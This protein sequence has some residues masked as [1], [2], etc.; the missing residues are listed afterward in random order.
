[1]T[2]LDEFAE[3]F[4]LITPKG[5][6]YGVVNG[7]ILE[8]KDSPWLASVFMSENLTLNDYDILRRKKDGMIIRILFKHI[9][10][11]PNKT[12]KMSVFNYQEYNL[13]QN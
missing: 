1:M 13:F 2:L 5:E 12:L 7:N 4:E 6:S 11:T 8:H 3:E 10:E 9:T